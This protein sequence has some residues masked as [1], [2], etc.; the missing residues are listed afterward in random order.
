MTKNEVV[1]NL[2]LI[3]NDKLKDSINN[4]NSKKIELYETILKILNT[5]NFYDKQDIE[6]T[7]NILNDLG[8]DKD[9]S[10]DILKVFVG[11][12]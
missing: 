9:Y 6:V 2:V 7:M 10:Y 4:K 5:P 1:K 11:D 8:I 3:C 12:K